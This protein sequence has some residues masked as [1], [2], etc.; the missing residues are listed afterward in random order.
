MRTAGIVAE[1]VVRAL[2][3]LDADER[4]PEASRDAVVAGLT[5]ELLAV[6]PT[7]AGDILVAAC[8]RYLAALADCGLPVQRVEDVDQFQGSVTM[9]TA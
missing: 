2:E 9:P 8:N 4:L 1:N 5:R 7:P 6:L 3:R